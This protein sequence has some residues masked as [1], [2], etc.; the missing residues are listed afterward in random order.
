[1]LLYHNSY[2]IQIQELNLNLKNILNSILNFVIVLYDSKQMFKAFHSIRQQFSVGFLLRGNDERTSPRII[3]QHLLYQKVLQ[4]AH[5]VINRIFTPCPLG[6]NLNYVYKLWLNSHKTSKAWVWFYVW[7][8]LFFRE[9]KKNSHIQPT[10]VR[11]GSL[12]HHAFRRQVFAQLF[13]KD[14]SVI[15]CAVWNELL[16]LSEWE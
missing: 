5:A 16:S 14:H 7:I 11:F 12:G 9:I 1:M 13:D 2:S 4:K 8:P 15:L 10:A 6:T 3:L